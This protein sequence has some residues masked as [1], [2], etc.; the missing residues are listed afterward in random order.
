MLDKMDFSFKCIFIDN[1]VS[2]GSR[3]L[4][5]GVAILLFLGTTEAILV[6]LDNVETS[7]G[8]RFGCFDMKQVL[9]DTIT[10]T[11]MK[12]KYPFVKT[13]WKNAPTDC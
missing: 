2:E 5:P 11:R 12:K 6:I 8:S 10:L 1:F 13:H 4:S 3:V 7:F 9:Y